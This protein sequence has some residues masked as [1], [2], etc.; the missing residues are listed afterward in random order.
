MNYIDYLFQKEN[1]ILTNT[2]LLNSNNTLSSLLTLT[3][4]NTNITLTS[5]N[6]NTTLIPINTNTTLTPINTNTTLTLTNTNTILTEYNTNINKPLYI[7]LPFWF[8]SSSNY[9]YQPYQHHNNIPDTNTNV[10]SF[11]LESDPETLK[12]KPWPPLHSRIDN[13]FLVN[14]SLLIKYYNIFKDNNEKEIEE[15][16]YISIEDIDKDIDKIYNSIEFIEI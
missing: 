8:G 14:D 16:E 5:T 13:P 7:P 1:N 4:T 11:A 12:H 9:Y 3:N 10:Y 15:I 2:T 6:T